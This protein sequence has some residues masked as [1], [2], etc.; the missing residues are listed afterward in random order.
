MRTGYDNKSQ[1]R[2]Y[3]IFAGEYLAVSENKVI[4]KTLL[5]SCISVCLRDEVSGISGINHFMLPGLNMKRGIIESSDARYGMHAMELLINDM[6]KRGSR[7][8]Y[9]KAK[10]FGGASVL[11]INMNDIAYANI[12]FIKEYLNMEGITVVSSDLGGRRGRKIYFLPDAFTVYLK[13]ID[14]VNILRKTINQEKEYYKKLQK[15]NK[16]SGEITLF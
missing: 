15:E 8:K 6:I 1:R 11:N 2:V 4:L 5:G 7:R 9:I 14:S 13:R 3:E 10:V 16:K 12:R